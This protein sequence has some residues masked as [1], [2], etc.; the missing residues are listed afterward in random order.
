[1]KNLKKWLLAIAFLILLG[2]AVL[3]NNLIL[4]Q[5]YSK[6]VM[7]GFYDLPKDTLDVAF[8]GSSHM[9]NGVLP[10]DLWDNYGIRAYNVGQ[11]GQRLSMTYYYMKEVIEKQHPDVVVVD[12]FYARET[13]ENADIANLH[14]SLD[15]LKLGK[16]KIEAIRNAA[17]KSQSWEFLYPAY[18]YHSR[19]NGLLE[20]D[21]TY[22]SEKP[23]SPTGGAELR[24][25]TFP[26]EHTAPEVE[27]GELTEDTVKWLNAI[28]ELGKATDTRVV[29]TVLPYLVMDYEQAAYQ[30]A[31][32]MALD[33]G[34]YFLD[35]NKRY[36]DIG[37]DFQTDLCDTEHLN[38]YGAR[39]V[40]DYFGKYLTGTLGVDNHKEDKTN[41]I[42]YWENLSVQ[43]AAE[44]QAQKLG[45]IQDVE[46][47]MQAIQKESY[48]TAI[49][50]WSDGIY[51]GDV[52]R[53]GFEELGLDMEKIAARSNQYVALLDGSHVMGEITSEMPS[54]VYED[55]L[56]GV[57]WQLTSQMG[58]TSIMTNFLEHARNIA[59][60]N[61]VVY[62]KVL[63]KVIDSVSVTD[64]QEI[65]R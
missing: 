52:V 57:K 35:F 11:H 40:T 38:P 21:F 39:K 15:N 37:F 22:L 34:A 44:Y 50:I 17:P 51:P 54:V 27:N 29:F 47:Y 23:A 10:V 63:N 9:L 60:I 31:G 8:L 61:I 53:K 25:G 4:Q 48:V 59:S 12:L 45:T 56:Y 26:L 30:T 42:A 24:W 65:K 7:R 55:T 19:W 18:L 49:A 13:Q 43:F 46:E 20:E 6:H 33:A 62:D 2:G 3:V 28:L 16:N 36:S 64:Q 41:D 58:R 5:K 1:M 32:Q 14:K